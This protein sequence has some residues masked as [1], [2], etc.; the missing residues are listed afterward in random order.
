MDTSLD[1]KL[2]QH[3][4]LIFWVLTSFLALSLILNVWLGYQVRSKDLGPISTASSSAIEA[5][6]GGHPRFEQLLRIDGAPVE[7]TLT[8]GNL[9]IYHFSATCPWCK[10]NQAA[11]RSLTE[12]LGGQYRVIGL[13]DRADGMTQYLGLNP[14]P[15]NVVVDADPLDLHDLDI[16]G[17]PQTILVAHGKVIHNWLGAYQGRVKDSIQSTLHVNLPELPASAN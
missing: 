10:R 13:V 9:L 17:T 8:S 16:R 4:N 1:N 5:T 2:E 3:D 6:I 11:I 15:F 14:Q 7:A 12:Q